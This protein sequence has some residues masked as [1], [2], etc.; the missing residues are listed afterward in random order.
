MNGSEHVDTDFVHT[1][2]CFVKYDS[3]TFH[4]YCTGIFK[5]SLSGQALDFRLSDVTVAVKVLANHYRECAI[6]AD[7]K[8]VLLRKAFVGLQYFA[9]MNAHSMHKY[10]CTLSHILAVS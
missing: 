3:S 5:T 10:E 6:C 4:A 2:I 9:N 7:K 8:A 1:S